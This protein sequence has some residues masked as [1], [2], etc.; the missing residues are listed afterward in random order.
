MYQV[1]DSIAGASLRLVHSAPALPLTQETSYWARYQQISQH[2][3]A[4]KNPS[5]ACIAVDAD[6]T[7]TWRTGP[8]GGVSFAAAIEDWIQDKEGLSDVIIVIP[9]DTRI[10]IATVTSA[11]VS[12]EA[13]LVETRA[14]ETLEALSS[15]Q[16]KIIYDTGGQTNEVVSNFATP[17]ELPFSL[18]AHKYEWIPWALLRRKMPHR[19]HLLPVLLM[20]LVWL[21]N[22]LSAPAQILVQETTAVLTKPAPVTEISTDASEHLVIFA[23]ALTPTLLS[24]LGSEN[25][26]KIWLQGGAL[27]IQG[28]VL[29]AYPKVPQQ[30][31]QEQGGRFQIT[32]QGWDIELPLTLPRQTSTASNY[33]H[34]D[35]VEALIQ[36]GLYANGEVTMEANFLDDNTAGATFEVKI[37][38]ASQVH[39]YRLANGLKNQPVSLSGI[40][41]DFIAYRPRECRVD[42]VSKGQQQ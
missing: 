10:Y 28:D 4:Q 40:A 42:L 24:A 38:R 1:A 2:I 6:G 18:H 36:A 5:H 32:P 8:G 15:D 31:A 33:Q 21:A 13:A 37:P 35:V 3:R 26:K 30:V 23:N 17:E 12:E 16:V 14:L 22:E 27:H 41:C 7:Q 29:N 39:L 19:I 11:L 9:L 25:L 20:V 34:D